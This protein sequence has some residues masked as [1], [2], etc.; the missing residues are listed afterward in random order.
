MT[1]LVKEKFKCFAEEEYIP[2]PVISVKQ[3]IED[4][5]II[6]SA[7]HA[8][9]FEQSIAM[10]QSVIG[11]LTRQHP[12]I[13]MVLYDIGLTEVQ[14]ETLYS[15]SEN[16]AMEIRRFPFSE[17]P[18]Q[19]QRIKSGALKPVLIELVLAEYDFVMWVGSSIRFNLNGKLDI[20]FDL[21]KSVKSG[22]IVLD[23]KTHLRSKATKDLVMQTV[24]EE[25]IFYEYSR[26]LNTDW[27]LVNRRT[28]VMETVITPW[29]KCAVRRKCFFSKRT[30][31]EHPCSTSGK[32]TDSSTVTGSREDVEDGCNID[33]SVLSVILYKI[34]EGCINA[35]LFTTQM[36]NYNMDFC[37]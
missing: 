19:L 9:N 22:I 36:I 30:V 37:S 23:G 33:R 14:N 7:A 17:Y 5:P 25:P 26:E 24:R 27:M 11:N 3:I 20:L 18:A 29:V 34:H 4:I 8:Q 28:D 12:S 31:S 16:V 32:T 13:Y 6:V 2:P 21:A 15:L 10:L 1:T 35:Y